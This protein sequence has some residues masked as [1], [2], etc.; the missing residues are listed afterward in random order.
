MSDNLRILSNEEALDP[1]VVSA[2]PKILIVGFGQMGGYYQKILRDLGYTSDQILLCDSNP[3][4][5]E[6]VQ[7]ATPVHNL[8][9]GLDQNPQAVFVTPNTHAHLSVIQDS[10][11]SG[12]KNIYIEKPIVEPEQQ[13]ALANLLK[14]Q[15]DVRTIVGYVINASPVMGALVD[16]MREN[17]L[18]LLSSI[19]R[20]GKRRGNKR[21]TA[22]NQVDEIIHMLMAHHALTQS[23]QNVDDF[24]VNSVVRMKGQIGFFAPDKQRELYGEENL[25]DSTTQGQ[26]YL[27]TDR[28]KAVPLLFQ[29]SFVIGEQIRNIVAHLGDGNGRHTHTANLHFDQ[30]ADGKNTDTG[31]LIREPDGALELE[32]RAPEV[33]KLRSLTINALRYFAEPNQDTAAKVT[34]YEQ[35]VFGERILKMVG[36]SSHDV[37]I[38]K[39]K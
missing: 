15:K 9:K 27:E 16:H 2:V 32:W 22:G 10:V 31:T 6:G 19:G 26:I 33:N 12:T 38:G 20:W 8:D 17:D 13:E 18:H 21:A 35:D 5:L 36:E 37:T 1:E 14:E 24:D 3:Q 23:T 39:S 30:R 11:E 4:Q 7:G 29:S 25:P 28:F 34:T